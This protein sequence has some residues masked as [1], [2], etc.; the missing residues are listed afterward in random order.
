VYNL[1][2]SM[3]GISLTYRY[4]RIRRAFVQ[5]LILEL[6][7]P[8]PL[9]GGAPS[10][11]LNSLWI[12]TAIFCALSISFLQLW[13]P[14]NEYRNQEGHFSN[15]CLLLSLPQSWASVN[16]STI[17]FCSSE[18]VPVPITTGPTLWDDSTVTVDF[19]SFSQEPPSI[20]SHTFGMGDS[21]RDGPFQSFWVA[22]NVRIPTPF[23]LTIRA[24]G[25]GGGG[26]VEVVLEKILRSCGS[27][28]S[29]AVWKLVSFMTGPN[30]SRV[31]SRMD[32]CSVVLLV[33][34]AST[35]RQLT[36]RFAAL[37][38]RSVLVEQLLLLVIV[39]GA[40]LDDGSS[41]SRKNVVT[42]KIQNV[43]TVHECREERI[44]MCCIGW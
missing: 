40:P 32:H 9:G 11:I 26:E 6:Y 24:S 20:W 4:S 30:C 31:I 3:L 7:V 34:N 19:H 35:A 43:T 10:L 14:G 21:N 15:L 22:R 36:G 13:S 42:H 41:S 29:S 33:L 2:P 17:K 8:L 18:L 28:C 25:G 38:T 39:G 37:I 5:S 12:K 27:E 44:F 23:E 1:I 16:I